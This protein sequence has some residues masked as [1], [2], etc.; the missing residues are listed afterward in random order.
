M[1]CGNKIHLNV[2]LKEEND[3]GVVQKVIDLA[4]KCDLS[5]SNYHIS[6]FRHSTLDEATRLI[7]DEIQIAYLYT[8]MPE[9]VLPA[10]EIYTAKGT[11]VGMDARA[12][13]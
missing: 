1:E 12:A 4:K 3:I 5:K 11:H 10:P 2:E 6:G 13:T 8:D 9:D 7:G